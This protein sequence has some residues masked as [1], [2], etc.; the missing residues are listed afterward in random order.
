MFRHS[1]SILLRL[2][3]VMLMC[4]AV[5]SGHFAFNLFRLENV[6]WQEVKETQVSL[7]S[8]AAAVRTWWYMCT[9][10]CKT[11]HMMV[12]LMGGGGLWILFLIH[13]VSVSPF[14]MYLLHM[15]I[16][17]LQWK[18][19]LLVIAISALWSNLFR[20][21]KLIKKPDGRDGNQ[22][23]MFCRTI[24]SNSIYSVEVWVI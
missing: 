12:F 18:Y 2:L 20:Q 16:S 4:Q 11:K 19:N 3:Q 8:M 9:S 22:I 5:F 13:S 17:Q 24:L 21:W 15:F 1:S 10:L 7:K 23:Y 6:E 14:V